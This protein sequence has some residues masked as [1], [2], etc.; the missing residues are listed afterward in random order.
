MFRGLAFFLGF[1][2]SL[3]GLAVLIGHFSRVAGV[4]FLALIP[5]WFLVIDV[6]T[7]LGANPNSKV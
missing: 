5:F 4:L 1:V 6:V 2:P 3:I 7:Y